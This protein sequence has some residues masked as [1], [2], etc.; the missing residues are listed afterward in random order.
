M[1]T[2][3]IRFLLGGV[4][5][6]GTSA[7]A[8]HLS[9][10]P[11]IQL[12]QDKEAHVF[13][14]PDF[15]E[16]WSAAEIDARHAQHLADLGQA[17]ATLRG[18]ATP[19]YVFHPALIARIHR[20]NPA[21]RWIILLRDPVE[22]AVSHYFMEHERGHERLPLLAAMLLERWRL[23]GHWLDFSMASPLR[24]HSYRAR[25]DY[26]RQLD[27]LFA[28]FPEDQVLLLRSDALLRDPASVLSRVHGFLG[29]EDLAVH[30]G[31][32]ER[33]F[34][35]DYVPPPRNGI[36]MTCLRWLMRR[37]RRAMRERYRL[38]FD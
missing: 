30:E 34:V 28:H 24:H 7:L 38:V 29:I 27:V 21:M 25:G 3:R 10:H 13:D 14:A 31:M 33:V 37:E 15:D 6:A 18:D 19:I 12:P 23:R 1:S 11:G 36:T 8:L 17:E 4:Q 35:G 9:R 2:P 26:A 22:R 16:R 5:K 20:Y 32:R